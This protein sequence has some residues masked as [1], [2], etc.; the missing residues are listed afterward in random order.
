MSSLTTPPRAIFRQIQ[1]NLGDRYRPGFPV[2]KELIQNAEDAGATVVR[3]V[4][5]PGWPAATN[6]LLRVPGF[7]VANDGRFE[8]KDAR[9]ILSFA[10][11]AKG[12]EA[13]TIGRFGFGQKAVFHLCDAFVAHSLGHAV[14]FSEVVN[15]CFNVIEN[16]KAGS[17]DTI[18]AGDL[19]LLETA[20]GGITRGFV[21]RRAPAGLHARSLPQPASYQARSRGGARCEHADRRALGPRR[22]PDPL[23]RREHPL[24]SLRGGGLGTPALRRRRPRGTRRDAFGERAMTPKYLTVSEVAKSM[25]RS[26]R[27]I[28]DWINRGCPADGKL[29]RLQAAKFGK[30]WRIKEEWMVMFEHRVRTLS[31]RPDPDLE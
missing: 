21:E 14:R 1:A 29:V 20:T 3:F 24:Q 2:L 11:T 6:P 9:G 5:H 25:R 22:P 16:T 28:R 18:D 17:W 31:G 26:E 8:T 30:S 15:P 13:A 19:A 4:S 7:V 27:C 12:D 10:D 23:D